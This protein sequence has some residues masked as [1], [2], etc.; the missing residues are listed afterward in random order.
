MRGRHEKVVDKYSA[1]SMMDLT[2]ESKESS[3]II[4]IITRTS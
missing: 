1:D 3:I 4:T 2:V